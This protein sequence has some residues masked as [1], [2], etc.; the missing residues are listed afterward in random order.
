VGSRGRAQVEGLSDESPEA[1]GLCDVKMQTNANFC[2][3]FVRAHICFILFIWLSPLLLSDA[4][5][6]GE[7]KI[8][9]NNT[10]SVSHA[11]KGKS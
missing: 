1:G 3:N 2:L 9:C 5:S 11:G 10:A 4:T 6:Y 7:I 8:V